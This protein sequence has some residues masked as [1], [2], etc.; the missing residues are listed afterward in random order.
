M[1]TN[2]LQ[3]PCPCTQFHAVIC[4]AAFAFL[5]GF[6][7][8]LEAETFVWEDY[9]DFADQVWIPANGEFP[10]GTEALP[11]LSQTDSSF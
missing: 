9:D 8:V 3:R 5:A 4:Y 10:I 1:K 2:F 6:S 7:T 11:R